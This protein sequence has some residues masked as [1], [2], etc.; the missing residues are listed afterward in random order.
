METVAHYYPYVEAQPGEGSGLVETLAK[1]A[2]LVITDDYPCFFYPQM[3]RIAAKS[4]PA[5]L[6]IVDS[7]CLIP[8]A[9]VGSHIYCCA[10]V[11]PSHAEDHPEIP[12]SIA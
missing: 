11:S 9:R 7:N 10:L 5:R 2:C 4:L 8:L 12:G 3:N 1:Q 6:E